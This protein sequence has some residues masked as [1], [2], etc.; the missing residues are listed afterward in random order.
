MRVCPS[1]VFLGLEEDLEE[2]LCALRRS[3]ACGSP[4]PRTPVGGDVQRGRAVCGR[5]A[6]VEPRMAHELAHDVHAQRVDGL[7]DR[8]APLCAGRGRVQSAHTALVLQPASDTQYRFAF[9][10]LLVTTV[11]FKSPIRTIDRSNDSRRST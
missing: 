1:V 6:E 10:S 9:P 5:R 7:V 4:G 3:L 11:R 2:A 8:R